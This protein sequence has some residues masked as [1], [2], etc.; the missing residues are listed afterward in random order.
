MHCISDKLKI[1]DGFG[2][3]RETLKPDY[4]FY[5][6]KHYYC[7]STEEYIEKLNKGDVNFMTKNQKINFYFGYN[8]ITYE[9][10]NYIE[11]KT[12]INLTNY[13]KKMK[14]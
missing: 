2:I 5:Y 12:G 9:K 11:N 1:C 14:H 10:I 8:K 6:F 13:K 7:K 3:E 4:K